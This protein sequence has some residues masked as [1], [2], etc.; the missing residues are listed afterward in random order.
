MKTK[1]RLLI[2]ITIVLILLT[3]LIAMQFTNEVNWSAF[4]FVIAAL[5]LFGTGF[6]CEVI[7]ESTKK[8]QYRVLFFGILLVILF[9]VWAE[10]AVGVFGTPFAGS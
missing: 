8:I 1:R 3:P 2:L 5:L 7:L 6:L 10:L 9:L 4:D